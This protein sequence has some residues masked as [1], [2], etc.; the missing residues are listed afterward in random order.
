MRHIKLKNKKKITIVKT[1]QNLS[2]CF[3]SHNYNGL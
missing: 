2:I 1:H 3:L